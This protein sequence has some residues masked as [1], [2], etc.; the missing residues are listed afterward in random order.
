MIFKVG[1]KTQHA[2]ITTDHVSKEKLISST[3][4]F[5][6]YN[7]NYYTDLFTAI[8]RIYAG[9]DNINVSDNSV[10]VPS[11]NSYFSCLPVIFYSRQ[12]IEKN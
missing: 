12:G 2:A 7:Y 6:E 8:D 1:T 11:E 10:Y 5:S 3:E 9:N 4:T